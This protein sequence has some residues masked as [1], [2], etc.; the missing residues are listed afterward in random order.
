[1]Q[2]AIKQKLSMDQGLKHTRDKTDRS[3]KHT[4]VFSMVRQRFSIDFILTGSK[5]DTLA[6]TDDSKPHNSCVPQ[7]Q[8]PCKFTVSSN[9]PKRKTE[10]METCGDSQT[11]KNIS[12]DQGTCPEQ[13][14][15]STTALHR[16]WVSSDEFTPN[17]SEDESEQI[18]SHSPERGQPEDDDH[19]EAS[20]KSEMQRRMRTAFNSQ[21]ICKLEEMFKKQRYLG[22]SE[23][24]KLASCLQLS[25]I[26]VKTWFQNRRM[27]LKRQ[28]Q[29]HQHRMTASSVYYPL[30]MPFY[31]RT[32]V[33]NLHFYQN[34]AYQTPESSYTYDPRFLPTP[35]LPQPVMKNGNF[36]Q[37]NP[38]YN[39]RYI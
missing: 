38:Y 13:V 18:G 19:G 37:Y 5:E 32:P 16:D 23:R 3:S 1:M 36:E 2:Q 34:P 14:V 39:N 17:C 6:G 29:D 20:L 27:K 24:K 11:F 12:S 33:N 22:A 8:P 10:H 28:M 9:Q 30:S 26:Q 21:Q 4:V 15:S 7:P 35:V 31:H 25:E